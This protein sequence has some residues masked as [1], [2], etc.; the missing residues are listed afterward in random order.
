MFPSSECSVSRTVTIVSWVTHYDKRYFWNMIFTNSW[1]VLK[2]F[3]LWDLLCNQIICNLQSCF[4]F[5]VITLPTP[6]AQVSCLSSK[7][8]V[9]STFCEP[10]REVCLFSLLFRQILFLNIL[11]PYLGY[12]RIL[13]MFSYAF[14]WG[15]YISGGVSSVRFMVEFN[16]LKGLFQIL[17]IG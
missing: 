3:E 13:L 1:C 12:P 5:L 16:D 17:N 8:T 9:H 7:I 4:V 10:I 2:S 6:A 15:P 14:N 11:Q